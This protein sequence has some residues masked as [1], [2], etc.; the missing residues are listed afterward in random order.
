MLL[1]KI[2][3][4]LKSAQL[5]KDV[6]KI[7]TLRMLL[8]EINYAQIRLRHD[9][10]EDEVVTV[11]Q[12]EVKK[13]W[14]ASEAFRA[15]GREEMAQK[16]EAEAEILKSYLPAQM[17]QEELQKVVEEAITEVGAQSIQEMGKVMG[18]VR[19]KVGS[20]VDPARISKEVKEKL[21]G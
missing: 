6:V 1:D 10:S 12:K 9:L 20:R 19:A 21:N 8:S 13:R 15:G 4:D 5:A 17:D 11:I 16:E 18:L 7:S 3:E 14:E 2:T